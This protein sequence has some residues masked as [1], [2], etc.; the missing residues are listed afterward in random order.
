M[1]NDFLFKIKNG[2]FL[3]FLGENGQSIWIDQ[4]FLLM[5]ENFLVLIIGRYQ[6][7]DIRI[8]KYD[9]HKKVYGIKIDYSKVQTKYHT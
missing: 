5:L 4:T 3:S 6:N 7:F 8:I 9:N 2:V 1:S